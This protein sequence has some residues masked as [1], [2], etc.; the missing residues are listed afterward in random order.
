MPWFDN[1]V[2]F[3]LNSVKYTVNELKNIFI[4]TKD[5]EPGE[6]AFFLLYTLSGVSSKHRSSS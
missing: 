6:K 5:Q 1:H 2:K 3:L 4:W